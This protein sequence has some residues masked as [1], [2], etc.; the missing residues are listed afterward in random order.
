MN[1]GVTLS[2]LELIILAVAPALVGG[3]IG[4]A[5]GFLGPRW[6]QDQKEASDKKKKRAEKFEELVAAVVEHYHWF[7]VMRFFFISGQ[8]SQPT[9]SPITKIEAIA[10][11]YFPEF[12]DSVRQLDSASNNYEIWIL[13]TGQKRI[14]NE[15][16]YEKLIGHDDVLTKYMDARKAFLAELRKFARRE[17]Q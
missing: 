11:T 14:R 16:G 6:L 8:G 12:E 9:L 15:P 2:Y 1:S 5:G 17:F 13:D 10:G 7:A 4:L 3:A